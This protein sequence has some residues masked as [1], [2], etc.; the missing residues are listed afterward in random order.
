MAPG[1]KAWCR[2][3]LQPRSLRVMCW[4]GMP[5]SAGQRKKIRIIG[6]R[7]FAVTL[8]GKT[9]AATGEPCLNVGYPAARFFNGNCLRLTVPSSCTFIMK[10]PSPEIQ[11]TVSSGRAT[12]A[13][14]AAGRPKPM[15]PRPLEV[16]KF[17]RAG[18]G[19]VLGRPHLVLADIGRHDAIRR[20]A[21]GKLLEQQRCVDC[22]R[23]DDRNA[24]RAPRAAARCARATHRWPTAAATPAAWRL[25]LRLRRRAPGAV[26]S[27]R[28]GQYPYGLLWRAGQR[29]SACR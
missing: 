10:E 23:R 5:K 2:V 28:P 22:P 6:K 13:P 3:P 14:T 11:I 7:G 27:A 29:Y 15:V 8:P 1:S 17:F 4:P 21:I 16:M 18:I 12:C 25:N 24:G 19:H 9:A 20:F 26:C